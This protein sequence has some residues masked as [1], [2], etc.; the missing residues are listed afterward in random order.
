MTEHAMTP[1]AA[2]ERI[3]RELP[4]L[5]VRYEHLAPDANGKID[6]SDLKRINCIRELYAQ[7]TGKQCQKVAP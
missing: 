1:T 3:L 6:P 2:R 4:E 7:A 5:L